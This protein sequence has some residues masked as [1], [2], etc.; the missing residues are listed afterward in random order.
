MLCACSETS[1]I[2]PCRRDGDRHR[3][4]IAIPDFHPS[5]LNTP[6][7]SHR[8]V[9]S[10]RTEGFASTFVGCVEAARSWR[11]LF[12]H[13][14]MDRLGATV[15]RDLTPTSGWVVPAG[16][17]PCQRSPRPATGLVWTLLKRE[18]ESLAT[19]RSED[20]GVRLRV[21]MR[22]LDRVSLGE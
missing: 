13:P 10:S 5:L 22:M 1:A 9:F 7:L 8:G 4:R 18:L 12:S 20:D 16:P 17:E 3:S 19:V 14:V 15:Y 21:V 6:R 11:D 2:L